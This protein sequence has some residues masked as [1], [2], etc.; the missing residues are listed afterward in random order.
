MN[1]SY[2]LLLVSHDFAP[3]T[4]ILA[5]FLL[6]LHFSLIVLTPFSR[7]TNLE[8]SFLFPLSS[9]R[10]L[11]PWPST[12]SLS[13]SHWRG[14]L[15]FLHEPRLNLP[16]GSKV[17]AQERMWLSRDVLLLKECPLPAIS[18]SYPLDCCGVLHVLQDNHSFE[19]HLGTSILSRPINLGDFHIR[20][21]EKFLPEYSR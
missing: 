19:V 12:I 2:L 1:F 4:D 10:T 18:V 5:P 6:L 13:Q 16:L 21:N 14:W 11:S 9:L 20:T 3:Y 8:S 17:L 7:D 15:R